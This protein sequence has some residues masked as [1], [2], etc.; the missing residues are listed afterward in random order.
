MVCCSFHKDL[1]FHAY[2]YIYIEF[3][4]RHANS[5]NRHPRYPSVYSRFEGFIYTRDSSQQTRLRGG[6]TILASVLLTASRSLLRKIQIRLVSLN[7]YLNSH[8]RPNA[9]C[10]VRLLAV[11]S[12]PSPSSSRSFII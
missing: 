1:F 9:Q 8:Y 10:N 7:Q 2:T 4:I 5:V 12:Y 6:I 11:K 3:E